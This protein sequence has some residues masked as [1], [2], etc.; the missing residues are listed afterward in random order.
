MG[1]LADGRPRLVVQIN[2]VRQHHIELCD[3]GGVVDLVRQPRQLRAA[4]D[5]VRGGLRAFTSGFFVPCFAVP[6]GGGRQRNGDRLIL[7]HVQRFNNLGI[8]LCLDSVGVCAIRQQIA[9]VV[10][11]VNGT[12]AAVPRHRNGG[13]GFGRRNVEFDRPRSHRRQ[14]HVHRLLRAVDRHAAGFVRVAKGGYRV[15]IGAVRQL[16][17]P[18]VSAL[19]PGL[20]IDGHCGVRR[21]NGEGHGVGGDL[22]AQDGV[23][24]VQALGRGDEGVAQSLRHSFQLR[25]GHCRSVAVAAQGAEVV[26]IGDGG[27]R[28]LLANRSLCIATT[29]N[30][31][32]GVAINRLR[33]AIIHFAH[34]TAS[35]IIATAACPH[36]STVIGF[37]KRYRVVHVPNKTTDLRIANNRS[38]VHAIANCLCRT[39]TNSPCNTTDNITTGDIDSIHTI[40]YEAGSGKF[41]NDTRRVI[42]AR[43]RAFHDQVSDCTAADIAKQSLITIGTVDIKALD[44]ISLAIKGAPIGIG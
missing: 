30:H 4:A 32:Y 39:G 40:L 3:A 7:G 25:L 19:C 14:R 42:S 15:R 35:G 5:L 1:I 24:V 28:G 23:S 2:V 27:R 38:V 43:Y 22:P 31:S 9:A 8:A 13:V 29:G 26:A 12:V 6:C 16:E 34:N 20:P 11:C 41:R 17:K 44:G 37:R 21:G 18:L 36:V 10:L 33:L